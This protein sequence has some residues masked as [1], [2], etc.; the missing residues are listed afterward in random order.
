MNKYNENCIYFSA[1]AKLPSD[2]PSATVY[3]AVDVAVIIDTKKGTIE[4]A[5]FTLLTAES[6][7]FLKQIIVGYNFNE[8]SVEPL[9][10]SIRERY[11]GHAQKAICVALRLLYE[12]YIDWKNCPKKMPSTNV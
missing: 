8:N 4:E 11:L 9:I 7:E 5:S 1:Y 3:K 10:K 2:M 12:K 6:A